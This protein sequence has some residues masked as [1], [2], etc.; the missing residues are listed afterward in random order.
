MYRFH[1]NER[2]IILSDNENLQLI[3]KTRVD[4]AIASSLLQNGDFFTYICF[5]FH[6][7]DEKNDQTHLKQLVKVNLLSKKILKI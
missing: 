7:Y 3:E 1:V 5:K 6:A 4:Q 2:Q